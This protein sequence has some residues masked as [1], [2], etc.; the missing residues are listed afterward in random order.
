MVE[1]EIAPPPV[2]PLPMAP[3]PRPL[4]VER[5]TPIASPS[6]ESRPLV[7]PIRP[8]AYGT[9]PFAPASYRL[10]S[11]HQSRRDGVWRRMWRGLV[12]APKPVFED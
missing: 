11:D 5:P 1:R 9:S 10:L 3:P 4:I 2:Q 12:G 7:L 8:P 6:R